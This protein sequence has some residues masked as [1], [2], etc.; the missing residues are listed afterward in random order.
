VPVMFWRFGGYA[1]ISTLDTILEKPDV[2]LEELLDETDLI[3]ELKQHNTKLI[4]F[5]RDEKILRRLLEYII[6]PKAA[7][8]PPT[9]RKDGESDDEDDSCGSE[10]LTAEAELMAAEAER[11]K[12]EKARLKYAFV[13]CEVLS[14]ETWSLV[15]ALMQ[16]IDHLRM[17]WSFLERSPPLDPLQASYFTKVNETLLDKKTEEMMS[18]VKSLN[19]IVPRILKHVDCPMIMDLLLKIIS[20]EKCEGGAGIVDVRYG[21]IDVLTCHRLT[22]CNSGCTPK[23]SFR[24][25]SRFSP[26]NTPHRHKLLVGISL[27]HSLRYPRTPL[28]MSNPVLDQ[29]ISPGS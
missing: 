8:V 4:E 26:V 14:S 5:L 23:T 24:Y 9:P 1:N 17:F 19:G 16:N 13:S 11:E 15:E 21:D 27:R 28:R 25:Y 29:M 18:F 10:R 20:M 2:T 12:N 7:Q 6:A 22:L 3:Q